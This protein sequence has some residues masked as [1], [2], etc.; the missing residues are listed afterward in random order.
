MSK[1]YKRDSRGR[2]AG[3]YGA[4]ALGGKGAYA[5]RARP[6]T[7]GGQKAS[8]SKSLG[9]TAG[10]RPKRKR[11]IPA[12]VKRQAAKGAAA[13]GGLALAAT[14][15]VALSSAI[16]QT[17]GSLTAPPKP[18]APTV[19]NDRSESTR[20]NPNVGGFSNV[21]SPPLRG[22]GSRRVRR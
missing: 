18:K 15:S 16:R 2:F 3:G 13:A 11:Q 12:I 14:A 5:G 4:G 8:A 10:A 19:F 21:P 9:S 1:G 6:G 20:F 17:R 7:G 22:R